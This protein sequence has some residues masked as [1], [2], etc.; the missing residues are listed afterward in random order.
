MTAG[1]PSRD[2]A[3]GLLLGTLLLTPWALF[4]VLS[5]RVFLY[6]DSLK[7]GFPMFFNTAKETTCGGLPRWIGTLDSGS[8]LVIYAISTSLT[9][10]VRL[11]ALYVAGCLRLGHGHA[12]H[13]YRIQ[14]VISYVMFAAGMFVLGRVLFR[15][16]LAAFYL[17]VATLYAGM[18]LD[19]THS[20]QVVALVFWMPWI[21][22]AAVMFH[23]RAGSPRAAWYLNGAA[24]LA[25]LQ[26]LDQYPHYTLLP[27]AV[28]VGLYLAVYGRSAWGPLRRHLLRFWP[29]AI[30]LAVTAFQLFTVKAAIGAY[31]PSFRSDLVVDPKVFGETGFVQPTAVIGALLPLGF[32]AGFDDLGNSLLTEMGHRHLWLKPLRVGTVSRAFIFR[33]DLLLFGLGFVPIVLA[34]AFALRRGD[35]RRL[36]WGGFALAL[37]LVALQ[38]TRLYFL[39]L[40]LPFFNVLRIYFLYAIV[41]MFAVLVMSGYGMDMCLTLSPPD[42]RRLLRRSLALVLAAI[43]TAAL[44]LGALLPGAAAGTGG[45]MKP[46]I[47]VDLALVAAGAACAWWA[48]RAGRPARTAVVLMAVLALSQTVYFAGAVH[49][50]GISRRQLFE[51]YQLDAEDARPVPPDVAADPERF[52]RKECHVF[53]QCYLSRRDTVSLR[54]DEDGTFLRNRKEA[55]FQDGLEPDVL[56]ALAG[57]TRPIF[58]LSRR[59]V[60]YGSREELTERLN[61]HA[62]DIDRHLRDTVYIPRRD[63]AGLGSYAGGPAAARLDW[64]ERRA[65]RIRLRYAAEVPVFLNA[66][67][68]YDRHWLA[69]V[70]GRR[71][72]VRRGNFNG[73]AVALPPGSGMVELAYRS[74]SFDLFFLTRYAFLLA[75]GLVAVALASQARRA[76]AYPS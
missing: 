21:V 71:V 70:N 39:L 76:R 12:L 28:G 7:H 47:A 52:R 36:A 16:R 62:A 35:R 34:V 68:T 23:R 61:A 20:A 44:V 19:A 40:R 30:V 29:A 54:R 57:I 32:L 49:L 56:R 3:A 42:R 64:L 13:L 10:I 33:L 46:W 15:R 14:G 66:A 5:W 27:L 74:R 38:Q 73:L 69:R 67:V 75:G 22:A 8:P 18:F 63:F 31:R 43:G 58:W 48:S 59:A 24:V 2:R 51:H 26:A 65:D 55:V 53:A 50:L 11:P 25:A 37:F 60:P 45:R 72:E 9:Q 1:R 17:F 6:H 4:Q 41:A